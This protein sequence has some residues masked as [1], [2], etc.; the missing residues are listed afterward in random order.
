[1]PLNFFIQKI[2]SNPGALVQDIDHRFLLLTDASL[3]PEIATFYRLKEIESLTFFQLFTPTFFESSKEHLK[4]FKH[5]LQIERADLLSL[6]QGAL[7]SGKKINQ[8]PTP[9]WELQDRSLFDDDFN[10]IQE[11]IQQGLLDKAVIMTTEKSQWIPSLQDQSYLLLNLLKSC[12]SHLYIYMHWNNSSGVIGAS[13]EF[14]F[15]RKERLIQTM[16]LAGTLD[17]K[18]FFAENNIRPFLF[19]QLETTQFLEDE[20]ELEEHQLVVEDLKEKLSVFTNQ[21]HIDNPRVLELPHL[22]HLQTEIRAELPQNPDSDV[23]DHHL[24]EQL[25]PSSALGLKSKSTHWHWLKNLKGHQK[26]NHFGAPLGIQTPNGYFCIVG[27]RNLEWDAE[28]SYLRAGCGI[29]VQS[30]SDSEWQE[31]EAKRESVKALLGLKNK[32][33]NTF[34]EP[35]AETP[36]DHNTSWVQQSSLSPALRNPTVSN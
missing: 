10:K 30:R 27:I 13:P 17:K 18:K 35:K 21:I 8:Q 24:M 9:E 28:G 23:F 12:P 3:N 26:L 36:S 7:Y 6:L 22:F 1:M 19:S 4:N 20:K 29:V 15:H 32:I 5:C 34:V 33:Q 31:L 25:H 2:F 16:A 14:L 11:H